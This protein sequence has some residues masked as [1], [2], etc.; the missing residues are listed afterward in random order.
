MKDG[1]LFLSAYAL[2][3]LNLGNWERVG[4]HLHISMCAKQAS[5]WAFF[6]RLIRDLTGDA[7]PYSITHIKRLCIIR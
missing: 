1:G 5:G 7:Y 4:K 6:F 2:L 3:V